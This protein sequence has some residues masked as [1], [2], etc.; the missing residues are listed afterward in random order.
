M[1]LS[2]LMA[3]DAN[4]KHENLLPHLEI[5]HRGHRGHRELQKQFAFSL[6]LCDLRELCELCAG[7]FGRYYGI[8]PGITSNFGSAN[9]LAI[10]SLPQSNA[11]HAVVFSKPRHNCIL[12]VIQTG[13]QCQAVAK[14]LQLPFSSCAPVTPPVASR[15]I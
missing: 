12:R 2:D 3:D 14:F 7:F 8:F 5:Q 11:T 6:C 13:G 4:G 9:S 15:L 10:S 1:A